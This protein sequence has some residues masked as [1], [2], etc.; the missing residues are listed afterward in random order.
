MSKSNKYGYS[1]VDIPT[2]AFQA[3]VGKFDPAEINELVQED[4]WTQYGQLELLQ[5]QNAN[6]NQNIEFTNYEGYNVHLLV[7]NNHIFPAGTQ[8]Y[9]IRFYESGVLESGNVYHEVNNEGGFA[10]NFYDNKDTDNNYIRIDNTGSESLHQSYCMYFYNL[11]D[12]TKYSW[13]S[14]HRI[15]MRYSSSGNANENGSYYQWGGGCLPQKSIVDKIQVYN[16]AK[17]A[18]AGSLSLYGIRYS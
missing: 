2:Q 11:L 4:K 18:S 1:G 5:T 9:G 7:V 8:S 3:N 16:S 14:Y 17:T 6:T 12:S 15:M 10:G 13:L